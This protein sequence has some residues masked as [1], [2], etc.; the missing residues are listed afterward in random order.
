M[1][2][3]LPSWT[4]AWCGCFLIW[5]CSECASFS[6]YVLSPYIYLAVYYLCRLQMPRSSSCPSPTTNKYACL[7]PFLPALRNLGGGGQGMGVPDLLPMVPVRWL[8]IACLHDLSLTTVSTWYTSTT[9]M[10][11][12]PILLSLQTL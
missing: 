7:F 6:A 11:L 2:T 12:S 9:S 4:N 8:D 3:Q 1:A 5:C 10:Y